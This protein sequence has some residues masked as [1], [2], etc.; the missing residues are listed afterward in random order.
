MGRPEEIDRLYDE[1]DD[2]LLGGKL[3]E[4]EAMLRSLDRD[5]ISLA[6]LLSALT[7]SRPWKNLLGETWQK[8]SQRAIRCNLSP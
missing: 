8:L 4:A 5:D 1:L 2:L 7:V 3:V 6:I